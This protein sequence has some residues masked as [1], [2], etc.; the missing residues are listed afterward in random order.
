MELTALTVQSKIQ[1]GQIRPLL[2][3][4]IVVMLCIWLGICTL[5]TSTAA[6]ITHMSI[7]ILYHVLCMK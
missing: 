6:C 2:M 3:V 4:P 7:I 1:N 5:A